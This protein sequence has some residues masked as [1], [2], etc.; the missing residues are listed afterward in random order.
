[1][2]Q[3]L[4]KPFELATIQYFSIDRVRVDVVFIDAST[5]VSAA[6]GG[7]LRSVLKQFSVTFPHCW[8]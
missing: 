5:P 2:N 8:Q 6:F 3:L 4:D 7:S 1:M